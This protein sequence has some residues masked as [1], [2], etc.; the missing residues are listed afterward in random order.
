MRETLETLLNRLA[1]SR[2]LRWLTN[3]A[4]DRGWDDGV[5]FGYSVSERLAKKEATKAERKRVNE[6]LIRERARLLDLE[7][8]QWKGYSAELLEEIEVIMTLVGKEEV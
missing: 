7:D 1:N 5:L 6:I 2:K 8:A 3:P 4:Y